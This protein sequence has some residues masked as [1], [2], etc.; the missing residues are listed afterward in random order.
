M[1]PGPSPPFTPLTPVRLRKTSYPL[2]PT[3]SARPVRRTPASP[4]TPTRAPSKAM[5]LLGTAPPAPPPKQ[6]RKK[7]EH[8]R[9]LPA[10]TL[11]EI[12]Q[13]FGNVPKKSCTKTAAAETASANRLGNV[14]RE[15]GSGATVQHRGEDGSMWLDLEEEQDFAWLMSDPSLS[16]RS[17]ASRNSDEDGWGRKAFS[18]VL[19][20]TAKAKPSKAKPVEDSFND[21]FADRAKPKSR[22]PVARSAVPHPWSAAALAADDPPDLVPRNVSDSSSSSSGPSSPTSDASPPPPRRPKHRPPPLILDLQPKHGLPV[23]ILNSPLVPMSMNAQPRQPRPASPIKPRMSV[24]SAQTPFVH[25]RRAPMPMS[26]GLGHP[27]LPRMTDTRMPL[28]PPIELYDPDE[29]LQISCFEPDSPTDAK[30]PGFN[31]LGSNE[32]RGWLKKVREFRNGRV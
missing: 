12:N 13:F 22:K 4:V 28:L 9:P 14:D 3:A 30:H 27:P 5:K 21:M 18:N 1:Q 25:P 19:A 20:P 29:E 17:P 32:R 10:S 8:F 26:I 6:S 31:R 15:I 2:T 11:N 23:I 24:L 16:S 7:R